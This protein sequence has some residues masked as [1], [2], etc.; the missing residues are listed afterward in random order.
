MPRCGSLYKWTRV[1]ED[2]GDLGGPETHRP[3]GEEQVHW[4][5]QLERQLLE[6]AHYADGA[7][8]EAGN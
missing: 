8:R 1:V 7:H 3:C 6:V 2:R 5:D 4:A